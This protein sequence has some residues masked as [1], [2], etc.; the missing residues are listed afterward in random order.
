MMDRAN[1]KAKRKYS[2]GFL[3]AASAYRRQVIDRPGLD[4]SKEALR[5]QYEHETNG[6]P[7]PDPKRNGYT[8]GKWTM[9]VTLA[10]M[11][12]EY[13]AGMFTKHELMRGAPALVRQQIKKWVPV[14]PFWNN[15]G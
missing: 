4:F 11:K 5:A 14:V 15:R 2:R 7:K 1:D 13:L 6:A 10:A 3:A 8:L 12:E 9:D